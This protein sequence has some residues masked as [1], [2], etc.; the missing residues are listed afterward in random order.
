MGWLSATPSWGAEEAASVYN[1]EGVKHNEQCFA[2]AGKS[3]VVRGV[4]GNQLQAAGGP[5]T[6]PPEE[7][8]TC[9]GKAGIRIEG[10]EA[11][12]AQGMTMYYTWPLEHGNQSAGFVSS[13]ELNE[14]ELAS[15]LSLKSGDAAGNGAAAGR[16][17]GEPYYKITPA[18]IEKSQEYKGGNTWYTYSVYGLP[19]GGARFA[20]MTWSWINVNEGGIA[21]AVAE[22]GESFYPGNVEPI[23]THSHGGENEPEN[24]TV[25]VRY[26]YLNS[27]E[28]LVW[29]WMVTSHTYEGVCSNNMS[30]AGGATP[31]PGTLCPGVSTGEATGKTPTAAMLNGTVYPNGSESHYY[32]QY[33]TSAC[34]PT[35]C[36][37]TQP[38]PPGTNAGS[39]G[40]VG[41]STALSGLSP[42]KT[43]HFRVVAEN[44]LGT[45]YG[46]EQT[47][48]TPGPVEATTGAASAIGEEQA[49][50]NGS[51]NPRGYA[52]KYYYEYGEAPAYGKKTVEESAGA[53][54]NAISAPATVTG[55]QPGMTY[56]FR[57]VATSGG[58]TSYGSDEKMT[59]SAAPSLA[60]DRDNDRWIAAEGADN[61]L[62][63]YEAP[64]ATGEWAG[65]LQ[66]GGTGTTYSAPSLGIDQSNDRWIA[67]EG[68][69]H[70]LDVYEQPQA[71][72]KW[73]GPLQIGG[74]GT[75][76]SAP[77][78]AIDQSNDRWVAVQSAGN[79]LGVYEEPQA[80]GEWSGALQVG[81]TGT[82]YSAPSLA[83]DQSN[84]RWVVVEGA[85]NGLDVYEAPQ[86]T[87][88]WA[89]PQSAGGTG[90]TYS[91]PSLA[92]DQSNDRW[93][94]TEGANSGLDVYEEPQAT[95]E[96]SGPLQIG[97]TSTTYS[98][99]SLAV[100]LYND[101]WVSSEGAAN[102]LDVYEAPQST[103][104]WAGPLEVGGAGTTW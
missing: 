94:A 9:S 49:Q 16:V 84:D 42:G 10:I 41:A 93:V 51:V 62:D 7:K 40:T 99:P 1:K 19:I 32:F 61:G 27:G 21:R 53:G 92:I 64:Q 43:Y 18:Q 29:G 89:G 45:S 76:Y 69:N 36:G 25:T 65:P 104:Q 6:E 3:V 50:L 72:G 95:G 102:S 24:G 2:P 103:G 15:K 58:I 34:T 35:S 17:P 86:S 60:V 52:T 97:G 12:K 14:H 87:G 88:Q 66:V 91:A 78:L 33:G 81:G 71:T 74:T 46:G 85:G 80:T 83:I 22:E 11:T 30:Y 98:A 26:G 13:S 90:T 73:S 4:N 55:M 48:T 20:M 39:S 28:K 100:D 79:G 59:T 101:R 63:V 57:L 70:T 67:V 68:A 44:G 31:L 23:T 54:T 82:T 75:T 47:F 77:S 37:S 5:V 56:H 96:W 8:E 38:V